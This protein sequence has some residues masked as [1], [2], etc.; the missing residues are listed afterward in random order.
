MSLAQGYT[1][2]NMLAL[3]VV[4]THLNTQRAQRSKCGRRPHLL[5]IMMQLIAK[6]FS[7][8][9]SGSGDVVTMECVDKLIRTS[10]ML[11]PI[12]GRTLKADSDII[13]IVRVHT[14]KLIMWTCYCHLARAVW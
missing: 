6:P 3:S 8:F 5:V 1:V 13:S 4:N 12:S 14:H 2:H 7:T 11:C 10:D 9:Q